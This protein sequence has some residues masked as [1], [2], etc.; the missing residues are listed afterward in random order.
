MLSRLVSLLFIWPIPVQEVVTP[1]EGEA[2]VRGE[3]CSL[4]LGA[5]GVEEHKVFSDAGVVLQVED[6]SG[7]EPSSCPGPIL[8]AECDGAGALFGCRSADVVPVFHVF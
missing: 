5:A 6:E 4:V 7:G 3:H 1:G 2:A 8:L